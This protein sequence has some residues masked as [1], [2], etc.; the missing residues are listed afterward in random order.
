MSEEMQRIIGDL[1]A[2]VS[3]L[4]RSDPAPKID[5]IEERAANH[6]E[7]LTRIEERQITTSRRVLWVIGVLSSAGAFLFA[8]FARQQGWM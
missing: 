7:R 5:R 2:R 1:L 6:G 4:E 8:S 3:N